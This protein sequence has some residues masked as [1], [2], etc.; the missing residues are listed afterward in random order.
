MD[1][2]LLH[3]RCQ[4]FQQ[5]FSLLCDLF[6][7]TPQPF[8]NFSNEWELLVAIILSAQCTDKRVNEVTEVLFSKYPHFSDYL[9]ASFEEL[10]QDIRSTGFYRNKARNI[11]RLAQVL[12]TEY[13]SII[14]SDIDTLVTLPGVGRKTAN[15]FLWYA[16]GVAT[17]ITVDTH[18]RR[19][20][21]RFDLTD[22]R[23]PVHIERDLMD[24]IPQHQWGPAPYYIIRYG[25]D[26]APARRYDTSQDP[27]ISVY[28]P[29]G[30]VFRV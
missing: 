28:P 7:E 6:P 25:R 16:R 22:S 3:Q 24:I 14:P 27:L 19:F 10:S 8:L 4:R 18:V 2:L 11:L 30:S 26:I 12:A 20:A 23:D 15:A 13:D 5:L 17:G 29:A 1:T 21:I 9:D